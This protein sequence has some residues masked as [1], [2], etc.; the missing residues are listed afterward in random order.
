[1]RSKGG[2]LAEANAVFKGID[3]AVLRFEGPVKNDSGV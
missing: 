2:V 1:M 3:Q